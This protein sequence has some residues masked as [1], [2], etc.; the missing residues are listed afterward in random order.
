MNTLL[1][2]KIKLAKNIILSN[3]FNIIKNST[4]STYLNIIDA[5]NKINESGI[6][7]NLPKL[8]FTYKLII[9]TPY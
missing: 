8:F 5:I 6:V 4:V 9:N 1:I 7:K 2:N 3:F